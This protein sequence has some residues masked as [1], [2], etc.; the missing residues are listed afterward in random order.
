MKAITDLQSGSCPWAILKIRPPCSLDYRA[1][2]GP[3]TKIN[4]IHYFFIVI[5]NLSLQDHKSLPLFN[6]QSS[7]SRSKIRSLSLKIGGI[8]IPAWWQSVTRQGI[9]LRTN[10]SFRDWTFFSEIVGKKDSCLPSEARL[11]SP[12]DRRS[13]KKKSNQGN[14]SL[15]KIVLSL[16]GTHDCHQAGYIFLLEWS[17]SNHKSY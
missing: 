4:I 1:R 7:F 16:P 3:Q 10:F 13:R 14:K 15:S 11:D 2:H 6:I 5:D 12:S 9:Q 17:L 8:Y